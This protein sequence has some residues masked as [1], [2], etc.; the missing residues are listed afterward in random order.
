MGSVCL[1][2]QGS[3]TCCQWSPLSPGTSRQRPASLQEV[4]GTQHEEPFQ[5][6]P[7]IP[8]EPLRALWGESVWDC[9]HGRCLPPPLPPA[10]V[11]GFLTF[12]TEVSADIL[13]S[14]PGNDMAIVV[15]RILFAV[16]IVTVY[17]IVLFLGR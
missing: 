8:K 6:L 4:L 16:S 5:N 15:A 13:M 2:P 12:G 10:G 14:Y 7:T 1:I 17:P 3:G 9:A 11:Y